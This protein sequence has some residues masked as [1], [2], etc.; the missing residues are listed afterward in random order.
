M[1]KYK[2]IIEHD[3][4]NFHGWQSQKNLKTIQGEIER[5][6][7]NLTKNNVNIYGAS[8]TDAGVHAFGQVAHFQLD[9]LYE[10]NE[11]K[12]AINHYLKPE[13]ISIIEIE[14][15][16]MEFHSR[17]SN[18]TKQ[19]IYKIINRKAPLALQKN[20]A[21]H[22]I[23]N[24]NINAMQEASKYLIGT[25][26]FTSFRST[27]CQSNS[28]IK[29]ID[30]IEIIKTNDEISIIFSAQSFLYNQIRIMVGT[31]KD[32]GIKKICPSYMK[33][34]IDGKNRKLASETAPGYG[35]YLNKILYY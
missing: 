19:Y 11:V 17:F 34:I 18:K 13:K 15:V 5:A 23:P 2:I 20:R 30:T 29:T 26:D 35:L 3:G 32:F 6:L 16:G 4:T 27:G 7:F 1:S 24:L 21:W 33:V 25:F 31:L 14:K 28:A 8:R 9:K 22:I 10:T 12:N